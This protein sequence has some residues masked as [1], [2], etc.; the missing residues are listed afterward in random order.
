MYQALALAFG[1]AMDATAVA[2]ARGTLRGRQ[3]E[4]IVLALLFGVFQAGMAALGWLG[5]S[6]VE[7]YLHG[8]DHW[9]AFLALAAI[10]AKMI[11]DGIKAWNEVAEASDGSKREAPKPPSVATY[12]GLAIATS[13]D[14][15]AAG[16]SLTL[17]SVPPWVAILTIGVVTAVLTAIGFHAGRAAGARIGGKLA[18]L[19]GL[20]LVGIGVHVL[21]A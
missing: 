12:L 5:G 20:V 1:L 2:A 19:G 8:W 11:Y 13:L 18:I 7:R 9:V 10:G 6:A 4:A 21:V 16:L 17:L 15:A 14:A 3:S